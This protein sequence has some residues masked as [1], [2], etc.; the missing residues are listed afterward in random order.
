MKTCQEF[1]DR[2]L[3]QL[4][5]LLEDAEAAELE[6]HLAGCPL[7]RRA[8]EEA[9]RQR[10]TLS[11]AARM[12]GASMNFQPPKPWYQRPIATTWGAKLRLLAAAAVVL[13]AAG[14][15]IYSYDAGGARAIDSRQT[16]LI[17]Q[18]PA[19]IVPGA[20]RNFTV[21]T[22]TPAGHPR[23]AQLSYR[24]VDPNGKL[25]RSGELRCEGN[26]QIGLPVDL[27]IPAGSRLEVSTG[28]GGESGS[29]RLDVA[30]QRYVAQISTDKPMYKPGEAVFFRALALERYSLRADR[31][32]QVCFTVRSP[33]GSVVHQDWAGTTRGVASSA[34]AVSPGM[35]GGEYSIEAASAEGLFAP[36]KR[37]FTIQAYRLPR[38]KKELKFTGE[39]YGPGQTAAAT[40][41]VE[42]TEGGPAVGAKLTI[43]ATVDGKEVYKREAAA[44]AGGAA[45]IEFPLPKDIERGEGLLS[46]AIDDGGTVETAAKA[47]PIALAKLDV[48]FYPE[49]GDLVAGVASR[50]YLSARTTLGKPAALKGWVLSASGSKVA[51]VETAHKGMGVF[52]FTPRAGERY[53]LAIEEPKGIEGEHLL[54]EVKASGVVLRCPA[55]VTGPNDELPVVVAMAG[56]EPRT[57]AVAAYCR[58]TLVGQDTLTA[59]AGEN[60][61]ALKI[62]PSAHG[63]LTVTVY[64]RSV[65]PVA[66]RLVYRRSDRRLDV[67]MD[68]GLGEYSPGQKVKVAL[69]TYDETGAPVPAALGV[70]VVDEGL[71]KLAAEDAPSMVTHYMLAT[72][73]AKPKDLEEADFYLAPGAKSAEA[74][75]LLLG[76]Q[77]W[78]R[79]AWTDPGQFV[80]KHGDDAQHYLA[81]AGFGAAP[82]VSDNLNR[83]GEQH[84][85]ALAAHQEAMA[86]WKSGFKI[87][88]VVFILMGLVMLLS[89]IPAP[90]VRRLA[91]SAVGAVGGCAIVVGLLVTSGAMKGQIDSQAFADASP[92]VA[93]WATPQA[94]RPPVYKMAEARKGMLPP[95]AAPRPAAAPGAGLDFPEDIPLGGAG[96]VA[97]IG[98]GG[99]LAG[100]AEAAEEVMLA[101]D[102]KEMDGEARGKA[103]WAGSRQLVRQYAHAY[104][105][106]ADGAR[107]DFTETLY[108]NPLVVTDAQGHAE[109]VFDLCD[110]VTTFLVRAD[111]HSDSGRLGLGSGKVLSRVPFYLEPKLPVELTFGD[112]LDLPLAVVNATKEALGVQVGLKFPEGL[113]KLS[114]EAE[115]KLEL[116]AGARERLYFPFEV[117][118]Q[119]GGA[120]LLFS[121]SGGTLQDKVERGIPVAPNGF[122]REFAKSGM[123]ERQ[124]QIDLPMPEETVPGTLKVSFKIYPSPLALM[125][126][127]EEGML[128]EPGGCFEQASS[129]NYPNVMMLQ[130]MGEQKVND[131][132]IAGRAKQVLARGYQLL[133]GYECKQKGYEWF[134]GDPGHEALSAYGLMEFKDMAEVHGVDKQMIERTRQWLLSRR[135]GKGGFQRNARALDSFG[136]APENITNA[137]ITWAVSEAG[138]GADI[139]KELTATAETAAKSD[140][141]YLTAL[142]ANAM[143]NAGRNAGELLKKLTAAQQKDGS[144][145]GTNGSITRSSGVNLTMETTALASLAWMRSPE[146]RANAML[147]VEWLNKNRKGSGRYGATQATVLV[148]KA[149]VAYSKFS[150]APDEDGSVSI[151]NNGDEIARF[152]FTKEHRGPINVTGLEGK[153]KAGTNRLELA[154]NTKKAMPYTLAVNYTTAKPPS[155]ESCA[156]RITT[157]LAKAK[158]AAGESV[159]L[160]VTLKNVTDKGQPM[161][162]AIVGL[163][164]GLIVRTDELKDLVKQG[165][166]DFYETRNREVILYWRSLA[167]K[168]EVSLALNPVAEI[169]GS[170]TGPASRVYLYYTDDVK[171]WVDPLKIEIGR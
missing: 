5:G 79:F 111:G 62:D 115:R 139:G 161:T 22:Q 31:E 167:P 119:S 73:V 18:G 46:V 23:E 57:L 44:N 127:G 149:L 166:A 162:T 1:Q 81:M 15:A 126:D 141:P 96:V 124:A 164:A 50:C 58:G 132:K 154:L 106:Q 45:T 142:A 65:T 136:G 109:I 37:S 53:H 91:F 104:Q 100:R 171:W 6:R 77:G 113:L 70:S 121:G 116:R 7:C 129:T 64:D 146:H 42:R 82:A 120:K 93:R 131:P 123:L 112:R 168:Q 66:E 29:L 61:L 68:S 101:K 86:P 36:E 75:D 27:N 13:A 87:G 122:P 56:S 170:F 60:R 97:A 138:S 151:R 17:V 99:E 92:P 54:P 114:G 9:R 133:A 19:V 51:K 156:V 108:W 160:D 140:D 130:F 117:V 88:L 48:D 98:A 90:R 74:L 3:D 85:L 32:H 83:I 147:A 72:E 94:A 152:D 14:A 71:L 165:K 107:R 76:T 41:S 163:P 25:I 4:Y 84:H 125:Q 49:G 155:D 24:L 12:E 105:K 8:A 28:P 143:L 103:R 134:G 80:K 40:L 69:H 135:D 144:I 145:T 2:L 110:S 16:R 21:R 95:M 47:I 159:R 35:P 55:G 158:A 148:L 11:R 43:T 52:S 26:A 157:A 39:S 169:P 67:R 78:R 10:Q 38:L 63:V 20:P 89:G 150:A 102:M 153:L 34:F 59:S 118:G 137:Y 33:R 30:A 128:A